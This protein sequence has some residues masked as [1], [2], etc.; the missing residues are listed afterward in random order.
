VKED[1][2]IALMTRKVGDTY[3]SSGKN[4]S[5]GLTNYDLSLKPSEDKLGSYSNS[6]TDDEFNNNFESKKDNTGRTP[7]KRKRLFLSNNGLTQ[8]KRKHH[9]K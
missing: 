4:E 8:K 9:L 3:L 1:V 5:L 7:I 6:W 2:A